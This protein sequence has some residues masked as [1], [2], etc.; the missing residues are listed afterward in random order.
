[1]LSPYAYGVIAWQ[2]RCGTM[3]R[4]FSYLILELDRFLR[5]SAE[6][7]C[8]LQEPVLELYKFLIVIR[9]LCTKPRIRLFVIIVSVPRTLHHDVVSAAGYK[10]LARNN[11]ASNVTTC[12]VPCVAQIR[13]RHRSFARSERQ[14]SESDRL[15]VRK[16]GCETQTG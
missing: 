14:Y 12:R 1:M 11:A 16:A 2:F 5:S 8:P 13:T 9:W 4:A 6:H 3:H 7:L 15:S 10:Y